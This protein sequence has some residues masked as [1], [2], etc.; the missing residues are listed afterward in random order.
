LIS[1]TLLFSATV[2]VLKERVCA[3][4]GET[5][6]IQIRETHEGDRYSLCI[7]LKDTAMI[8]QIVRKD[9]VRL[10]FIY[11]KFNNL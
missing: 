7:F 8:Y 9:S 5:G 2:C 10:L 4:L 1:V 3:I 11:D 6:S